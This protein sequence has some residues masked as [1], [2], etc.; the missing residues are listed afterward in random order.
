MAVFINTIDLLGDDV[1]A[2]MIVDRSITEF[3]DDFLTSIGYYAFSNCSGLTSVSLPSATSI[4][5]NAFDNCSSLVS[6][7]L[8]NVTKIGSYAFNQCRSLESISLSKITELGAGV[9]YICK[10]LISVVLP[11]T[12]PTKVYWSTFYELNPSCVFHIPAGSYDAYA[13]ISVWK[14]E[15]MSKY[16]FVEDA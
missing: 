16:Q 15:F 9:F 13:A 10:N 6:V 7:T 11:A 8:P 14:T 12:P 5:D 3:N 2:G 1:T 4:Y